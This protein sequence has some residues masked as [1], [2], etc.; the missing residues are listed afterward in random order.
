MARTSIGTGGW[1]GD[2]AAGAQPLAHWMLQTV[3][4]ATATG[5]GTWIA[6]DAG[7][8]RTGTATESI[9][10]G[11]PAVRLRRRRRRRVAARHFLASRTRTTRARAFTLRGSA[12]ANAVGRPLTVDVVVVLT[13]SLV[14]D[15][16]AWD[17]T[18]ACC[19]T[20]ARIAAHASAA[21]AC[22]PEIV[23]AGGFAVVRPSI[24]GGIAAVN[25]TT[26]PFTC[27]WGSRSRVDAPIG[28]V[29]AADRVGIVAAQREVAL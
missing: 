20:V 7:A 5:G 22:A 8:R 14:G 9:G 24:A 15:T 23:A 16:R 17:P 2:V 4:L 11:A 27:Q 3:L 6:P 28:A 10:S 19:Y 12:A 1:I 18:T 25:G 29:A 21:G 26:S 13:L